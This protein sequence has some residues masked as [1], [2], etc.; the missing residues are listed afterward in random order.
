MV[1]PG[2]LVVKPLY[3]KLTHDTEIFGKMDPKCVLTIGAQKFTTQKANDMGKNPTWSDT[4]SF[5]ITNEELMDVN[6]WDADSVGQDDMIGQ[7]SVAVATMQKQGK[8][9]LQ[10][11]LTYKGKAAGQVTLDVD[12][13]PDA[14]KD[15]GGAAGGYPVGGMPYP[16]GGMPYPGGGGM[17]YPGGGGMPYPG[18]G[19]MPYPGGGGMPY[20]VGGVPMGGVPMGGAPM[21]GVPLGGAHMGGAPHPGSWAVQPTLDK[22]TFKKAIEGA[23]YAHDR[24]RSGSLDVNEFYAALCDAFQR[25]GHAPPPQDYCIQLLRQSDKN[26]DQRLNEKEF[27]SIAKGIAKFKKDKKDKKKK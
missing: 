1:T 16:G 15:A 13:H 25:C 8:G 18:G 17:P 5:R 21:G 7:G 26:N 23:F 27:K 22:K 19:G 9:T 4:F 20:P 11:N 24:D 6:V 14:K 2:N 10:C 12:F 3:G